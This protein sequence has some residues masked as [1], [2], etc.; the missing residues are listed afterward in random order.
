MVKLSKPSRKLAARLLGQVSFKERIYG[1]REHP[2]E[3]ETEETIYS[4]QEA[5]NMMGAADLSG[6]DW[7]TRIDSKVL[8]EWVGETLGDK[9]LAQAISEITK[10][11][12][13]PRRPYQQYLKTIERTKP[14]KALRKQ[15]LKR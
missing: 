10:E 9:E 3:G 4:F 6:E 11:G 12:E 2:A 7:V 8:V 13:K 1:I 14:D 15:R 5:V